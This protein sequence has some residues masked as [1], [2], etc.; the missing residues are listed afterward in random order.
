MSLF[1][2]VW[3]LRE[4]IFILATDLFIWMFIRM[5]IIKRLPTVVP[6]LGSRATKVAS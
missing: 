3:F 6:K 1:Y 4:V 5:V 2:F